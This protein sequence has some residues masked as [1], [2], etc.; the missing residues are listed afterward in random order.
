MRI[1]NP[2]SS[3]IRVM[4]VFVIACLVPACETPPPPAQSCA[5]V[6]AETL[7]A[8]PAGIS[9][10]RIV[11]DISGSM[12]GFAQPDSVRLFTLHDTLE[13]TARNAV[14]SSEPSPSI[15]RCSVGEVLDCNSQISTRAFDNPS[16][17]SALESRLDLFMR[18]GGQTGEKKDDNSRAAA[19]PLD[20]HRLSILITDGMDASAPEARAGTPC[21]GGA[22]PDCMAHL[23][24]Q[25][26]DKG[27]GIWM[28]LLLMPFNG[29]HYA[30][31]PLDNSLWERVR[32][33][34]A[35]LGQDSYFKG[36]TLNVK[37]ADTSVPFTSY[38]YE[39]VKPVLIIAL[40]RDVQA[41]RKFIQEFDGAIKRDNITQ[42]VNGVYT[43]E[44]APLSVRTRQI[45][46]VSLDGAS[47]VEGVRPVTGKRQTGLYDYL[48]DCDRN[49]GATFKVAYEDKEGAQVVPNGVEESLNLVP[50]GDG[51]LPKNLLTVKSRSDKAFEVQLSC[52]QLREGNYTSC[53]NLQSA[54]NIADQGAAF[55]SALN[56]DNVYE[57]PERL[58]GLREM[59]QKV[60]QS[61]TARARVADRIVF[62]VE[63]KG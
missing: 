60:L 55:W 22:D 33:H 24:K 12:K 38:R 59:V 47:A 6:K 31:R 18:A 2:R 58:Y 23:L 41:G 51:N 17:Y 39:G 9:G 16:T 42:P 34:V 56:A 10:A 44:V 26:A 53:F 25:H 43:M 8:A 52:Q 7:P 3:L 14:L 54:F 32:Q 57:A 40:S 4:A 37:R 62:R 19:T 15:Q 49:G 1:K 28:A 5:P 45:T 48:V 29:T 21:L 27:Y 13:R 50:T 20:P 46:K 35:G 63:R 11:T 30:E 61:V 36:V